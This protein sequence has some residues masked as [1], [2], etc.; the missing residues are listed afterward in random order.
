MAD[1][2]TVVDIRV[3]MPTR[4]GQLSLQYRYINLM[5]KFLNR[6]DFRNANLGVGRFETRNHELVTWCTH[7]QENENDG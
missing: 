7:K 3:T 1:N 5:R 6:L 4:E 2:Y